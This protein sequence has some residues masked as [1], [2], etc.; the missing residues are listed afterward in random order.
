MRLRHLTKNLAD[1]DVMLDIV[2]IGTSANTFLVVIEVK[3]NSKAEAVQTIQVVLVD[4]PEHIY[5][6]YAF[7]NLFYKLF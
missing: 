7:P 4:A 1:A 2:I 3:S 5:R 6:V